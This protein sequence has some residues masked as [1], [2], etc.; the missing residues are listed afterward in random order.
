M[1]HEA[2]PYSEAFPQLEISSAR[3]H[4]SMTEELVL[5]ISRLEG[6]F[7]IFNFAFPTWMNKL[8]H[9]PNKSHAIFVLYSFHGNQIYELNPELQN[10]CCHYNLCA[11][12][13]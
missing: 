10:I 3:R 6:L 7:L 2:F 4:N 8:S 11:M 1:G 13:G 9:A 5:D 12:L